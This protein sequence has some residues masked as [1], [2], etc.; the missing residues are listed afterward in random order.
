[1]QADPERLLLHARGPVGLDV[2]YTIAPTRHGSAIDATITVRPP[3]GI[4]KA[5]IARAL[6]LLLAIGALEM[7]LARLAREVEHHT[8]RPATARPRP[9]STPTAP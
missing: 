8:D 1:V 9:L 6:H 7:A 2:E 5:L 3:R 4:T